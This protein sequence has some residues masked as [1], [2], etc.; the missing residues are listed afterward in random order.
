[1]AFRTASIRWSEREGVAAAWLLGLFLTFGIPA[2]VIAIAP[3]LLL[4]LPHLAAVYFAW[5]GRTF[6]SGMACGVGLLVNPK[7]VLVL[8]AMAIWQ[9]RRLVPLTIGFV[10]P[11]AIAVVVMWGSGALPEY[12]RQVWVMGEV[13]SRNSPIAHPWREGIVRTLAWV[14]FQS[15]LLVGAAVAYRRERDRV[16]WVAWIVLAAV[17]VV[18]GWRF[19]PRYYFLLLPPLVLAA[20]R[21]WTSA[22]W[23]RF[24]L[25]ALMTVPL[26][27]FGPRYVMLATHSD[28]NWS[29]LA[30][31]RD[32]EA[33]AAT[34]R[35]QS[36]PGDTLLV[37]GYRP[38]VFVYTRLPAG[39]PYL[40]SQPLTGV[41]A[42]RH[43]VDSRP[44]FPALAANDRAELVKTNPTFIVDG[45][46]P[47]NPR[48]AITA[49]PEL[50]QWMNSRRYHEIGR[51]TAS[52]VYSLR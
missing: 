6:W 26:A 14:G 44:T 35:L 33:A 22:N 11:N 48:L 9:W 21:A 1:M 32:S 42:D 39:T 28:P 13:Y 8:A 27:R 31:N 17:G 4:I 23:V 25:L 2:A 10:L 38:D 20:S 40:D 36:K 49:Y 45:L 3:D 50:R 24:V 41:F 34:I 12:W 47:A 19:F 37:W 5:R 16:K 7:A 30:L 51:T 43:L 29:D 52:V 18:A 46:G 15:A